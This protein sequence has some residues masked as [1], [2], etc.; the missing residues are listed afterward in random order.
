MKEL[1]QNDL[2]HSIQLLRSYAG[3]SGRC[4]AGAPVLWRTCFAFVRVLHQAAGRIG[5]DAVP[6]R[7]T[8]RRYA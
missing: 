3:A 8:V 7:E 1:Q 2:V 5:N 6:D 4:G